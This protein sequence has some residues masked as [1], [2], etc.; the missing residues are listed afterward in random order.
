VIEA[1]DGEEAVTEFVKN[2]NKIN[3][4]I[5]DLVMPKKNGYRAYEEIRQLNPSIKALFI[6]GYAASIIHDK[7]IIEEAINYL[8]KPILPDTLLNEV[9]KVLD[10]GSPPGNQM[11][12]RSP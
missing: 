6:S 4:L 10:G 3:V 9:R 5:F 1:R 2:K 11:C 8:S 7:K 12:D